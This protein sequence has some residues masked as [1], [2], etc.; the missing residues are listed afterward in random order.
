MSNFKCINCGTIK[1][2]EIVCSCSECGNQMFELPYERSAMLISEIKRYFSALKVTAVKR[3]DFVFTGK[4]KDEHRFPEFN[5]IQKYI[6]AGSKTEDFINNLLRTTEQFKVHFTTPFSKTYP[7]AFDRIHNLLRQYDSVLI[8]AASVLRPDMN[9]QFEQA[10][11]PQTT[12]LYTEN[13]NK[14]LWLS[15]HELILLMEKLARKIVT[16]VKT[17]NLYG[18]KYQDYLCYKTQ[19]SST[20]DFKD[21]LEDAILVTEKILNTKYVIDIMD[22]GSNELKEMLTCLL[23]DI[24]LIMN[25]PLFVKTYEYFI[26]NESLREEDFFCK[27]TSILFRRYEPVDVINESIPLLSNKTEEEI[28]KVYQELIRLDKF[29]ILAPTVATFNNNGESERMLNDLIGLSAIKESVQ[30]IK[31]YAISNKQNKD[32]NLHMCF[33]G[34]PGT[35]KTEVARIIAGILYENHILPTKKVIEVDR[36]G[37]VSPYFGATAEKTSSVIEKAMGG[38]LFIDEAYALNHDSR[39]IT[40]YG[41]EAID[42][43]VKAMEDHRGEFCVILAGYKNPMMEMISLN[44]GFRSRIQFEIDFPNYS[45]EELGQIATRMLQKKNYTIREMALEKI[46]DITDVKRREPNFANAREVRNILDGAIMCQNLRTMGTEDQE[47]GIVDVTQYAKSLNIWLSEKSQSVTI[48]TPEEE[49]DSLV[50]LESVKRM[51]KKIKAFA[52]K[53]QHMPDFN[54]HMAFYGNPG[55]GKT[56]VARILSYILYEAGVLSEA[57]MIETDA[58]GLIGRYVGETAPKTQEKIAEAMGGVLFIDEAYG[59]VNGTNGQASHYGEEAVEILLKKMED[60]RGRFCVILAGYKQE[61]KQLLASNPGLE[62][63]VQFKLEFPDY[64]REELGEIAYRF[65]SKKNYTIDVQA[66]A[67]VLDIMDYY[68]RQE[69]FA[70]ARTLRNILDQVI[71]NQNLRTEDEADN[72]N[73]LRIDVE[74]YLQDEDID[75]NRSGGSKQTIG[76]I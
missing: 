39:G 30:K 64:S 65:L 29:G 11:F 22:D 60:C 50:G 33:Y 48:L 34:N 55:T 59:L 6:F 66:L 76:F 10:Q 24:R 46:L 61:M 18:K 26:E 27:I 54:L 68:S 75:L 47:I 56:E 23:N 62:S 3:E 57:K 4:D 52:K 43:L 74:E 40:D 25:A 49:L 70:N 28:L 63:R 17:N 72:A 42:A 37:L 7:V 44:P 15:A 51:V 71:M 67:L 53:N 8:E 5:K 12:L 19:V 35:G 73:I 21:Q 13:L 20:T 2:S 38:V 31:A 58:H 16:F 45:R 14:Y 36:S 32:L 69:N 41:K 9:V 1:E